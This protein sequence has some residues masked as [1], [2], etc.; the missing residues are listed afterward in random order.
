MKIRA[1]LRLAIFEGPLFS[2]FRNMWAWLFR[3]GQLFPR[4][5]FQ[6][7]RGSSSF[8]WQLSSTPPLSLHF[9]PP[10]ASVSDLRLLPTFFLKWWSYTP[11]ATGWLTK[12]S[13]AGRQRFLF[14]W[15]TLWQFAWCSSSIPPRRGLCRQ[16]ISRSEHLLAKRYMRINFSMNLVPVGRTIKYCLQMGK[17]CV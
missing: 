16:S 14:L 6:N 17:D 13:H 2:H 10:L 11:L 5:C 15:R 8:L 7:K 3:A 1:S 9:L 12:K 4:T